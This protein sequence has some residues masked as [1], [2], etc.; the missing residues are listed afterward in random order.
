MPLLTYMGLMLPFLGFFTL[1][2]MPFNK[3]MSGWIGC[4]TVLGAF[5]CFVLLTWNYVQGGMHSFD[6]WLFEWISTRGAEASFSLHIDSQALL[7]ALIVTG[8]G[9]LIHLYSIGYMSGEADFRRYFACLN[10][11][12]AA[13]LLLV[14]AGHLLLLFIGWEGVGLASYLLIGFWYR[15]PTAVRAATKAFIVNRI[16]DLGLLLGLLLTFHLFGT[17][18]ITE[19]LQRAPDSFS[20]NAF[21]LVCLT[22]LYFVGATGKS[23]QFPLHVWLPDAMEGPTPVSALIHAATMVTAGVYL[24]VRMHPLF[25]LTPTTLTIVG[26]IGAVTSLFAALCAWGQNDL[27]RVLAYSTISQLGLMFLACGSGAFYAALFHLTTH[28]FIKALLFLSA[29]NVVHA[30][31]GTTDMGQMRGRTGALVSTRRLFLIGVI[32][33]SGLPPFAAFFSKDLVL[34]HTWIAFPLLF[35]IGLLSSILTGIY[36]MRAYC[37]TFTGL[38][39]KE[40]QVKEVSGVM[41]LPTYVLAGLSLIGGFLGFSFAASPVLAIFLQDLPVTL[42]G[43]TVFEFTPRMALLLGL[44]LCGMGWAA[45]TY[46]RSGTREK[47]SGAILREGFYIDQAL[48]ALFLRPVERLSREIAQFF[49]PKVLEAMIP[50]TGRA[51]DRVAQ[52]LKTLQDGRIRSYLAWMVIG[53]ALLIVC[54]IISVK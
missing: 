48:R 32:A 15:R 1:F 14:L 37:L 45:W 47:E 53:S 8:I 2:L 33:L 4:S 22:L 16:G 23:A 54:L 10:L 17:G 29:G 19:I 24:L 28:A 20:P 51:V 5:L 38:S 36:L 35:W 11:F 18:H 42:L 9:Y 27:K 30:L 44:T 39:L 12:I 34:E 26:S 21:L 31:H 46:T 41:L 6:V 49:E 43:E 52:G 50:A 3:R 13:M 7:M 40:E 25:L